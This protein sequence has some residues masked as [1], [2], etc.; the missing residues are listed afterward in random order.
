MEIVEEVWNF[1]YRDRV[2]SCNP[3]SSLHAASINGLRW[4]GFMGNLMGLVTYMGT[5][6]LLALN[7]KSK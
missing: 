6:R 2:V 4:I 5:F 3:L 1:D 7:F